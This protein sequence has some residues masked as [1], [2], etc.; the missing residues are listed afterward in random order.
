MDDIKQRVEAISFVQ[1][2][3][4]ANNPKSCLKMRIMNILHRN[5]ILTLDHLATYTKKDFLK[6]AEAGKGSVDVLEDILK[7]QGL[8][9]KKE[10]PTPLEA[11][12]LREEKLR[13]IIEH[14][15]NDAL[16]ARDSDNISFLYGAEYA[17]DCD[18]I[19]AAKK[20]LGIKE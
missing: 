9:F 4:N 12:T 1:D 16:D 8:S 10:A 18:S 11:L 6:L 7:Q 3:F 2:W 5:S 19:K 13:K 17:S 20:E 15:L 14:L